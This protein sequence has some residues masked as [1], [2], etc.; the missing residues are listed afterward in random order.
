MSVTQ[1]HVNTTATNTHGSYYCRCYSCYTKQGTR[2][3]LRQCRINSQCYSYNTRNPSNPCQ[4]CHSAYKTRWTNDNSLP[5]S[6]GIACTRND[7]APVEDA[8]ALDSPACHAKSVTMMHVVLNQDT[9][10]SLWEDRKTCFSHGNLRPGYPCQQCDSNNKHQWTNNN[11]LRC[12]DNN[13]RTKNDRCVNGAC[14]GGQRTCFA[15]NQYKPG[16][17]CQWCKPGSSISTW[18]NRDGVACDDSNQCTRGDTCR[19]GQCTATPFTCNSVCQFCNGNT[20]SLKTGFG[21]VNNKCTCK[22]AG[23]DYNHQTVNPSNQFPCDDANNCT[24]QDTCKAG[25]CVGQGYSCQSSYPSSSCIRTSECVGDGT[26]S[27]IM[28]S[29]GTICRPAV[30]AC[31]QSERCNGILG[32][33]PGAVT[34]NIV[35][36]MGSL[37]IMSSKF[38]SASTY[39]SITDRLFLKISGFSVSCG[40]IHLRWS[41]LSGTSTCSFN[42]HISGNLTITNVHHTL[43]GLTLQDNT[44]YKVS[45]SASDLRDKTYQL[46]CQ[47]CYSR[48][49][50]KAAWWMDP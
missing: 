37:Q 8:L 20:C 35:L 16:N 49:Y 1:D 23:Q 44:T 40:Q 33:C 26:C 9:A 50:I 29:N 31:D 45:I 4:K 6:D 19:S 13:L 12:S 46:V 21:F 42:S 48:G 10:Q 5:C 34:D 7:R 15:K 39:Q 11:N 3:D 30:D 24:K 27:S 14:H 32:T 25:R 17:P 22:I 28:R 36:K 47:Q 2:C 38:Q 18:S 43:P 41:V